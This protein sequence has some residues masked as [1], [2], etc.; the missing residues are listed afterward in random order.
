MINEASALIETRNAMMEK[1]NVLRNGLNHWGDVKGIAR[2]MKALS[3]SI[4][5]VQDEINFKI[6]FA[7]TLAG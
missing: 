6:A 5:N 3:A 7:E 1:L 2:R 4:K